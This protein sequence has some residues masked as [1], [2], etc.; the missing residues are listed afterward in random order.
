MSEIDQ[1]DYDYKRYEEI[2]LKFLGSMWRDDENLERGE[3]ISDIPEVKIMFESYA[4][5]EVEDEEGN[6]IET[7]E[8]GD[9]NQECYCIFIHKDSAQEDFKFPEHET[10]AFVFGS[11]ILHRS[12]E[13]VCIYAWYNV[14]EDEWYMNSLEETSDHDMTNKEVMD[15]LEVLDKRWFS[16]VNA[17]WPF[18]TGE[19]NE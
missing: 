10:A 11:L 14:E 8:N 16:P 1:D 2:L 17:K 3:D 4:D 6:Y 18:P 19:P 5:K 13:E 7:I 12:A 9:T 15:I